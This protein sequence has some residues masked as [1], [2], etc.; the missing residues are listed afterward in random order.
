MSK[1]AI[2]DMKC[3]SCGATMEQRV[4][5]SVYTLEAT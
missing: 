1:I 5:M 4:V 3:A 2:R